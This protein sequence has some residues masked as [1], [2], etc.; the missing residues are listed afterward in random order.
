MV[1]GFRLKASR[2]HLPG[3]LPAMIQPML[4]RRVA[5]GGRFVDYLRGEGRPMIELSLRSGFS[6]LPGGSG[7]RP[8]SVRAESRGSR[9]PRALFAEI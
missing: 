3:A 6:N 8:S 4:R 7:S 9:R 1:T 2:S 5:K